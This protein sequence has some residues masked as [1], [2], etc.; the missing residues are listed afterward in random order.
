MSRGSGQG[1]DQGRRKGGL[2][3]RKV[4]PWGKF[5]I[6]TPRGVESARRYRDNERNPRRQP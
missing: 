6:N 2:N 3:S 4:S 1:V 5:R